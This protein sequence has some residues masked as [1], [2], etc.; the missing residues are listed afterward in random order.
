MAE[1]VRS[2]PRIVELELRYTE[3]QAMLQ[4]LSEVVYRQEK[5]LASLRAEVSLLKK[6]LEADPGLVEARP[7]ERPPHY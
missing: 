4:S 1:L 2:D 5:D 7:D 3:Q 6:K